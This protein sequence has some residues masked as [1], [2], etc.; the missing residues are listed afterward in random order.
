M[1][2][3]QGVTPEAAF[4]ALGD[5]LRTTILRVFADAEREG[6]QALTFTEIYERTPTDSTSRLSYHLD[7]LCEVFLRRD[8][9]EY[10]L[11]RAGDRVV[12]AILAGTY[13]ERPTFEPTTV[14]G[15]C[16]ACAATTLRAT[17][18]DEGLVV[19]CETCETTVV[20]Y[21][22]PPAGA[23]GQSSEE[24]LR[25]CDRRSHFEY[26]TALEGACPTCGGRVAVEIERDDDPATHY[27]VAECRSC[28]LRL[29][30]PL[31]VR[32][33][34]H[35]AV[36]AFY[37]EHGVDV[38]AVTFWEI[39]EFTRRWETTVHSDEPFQ[40]TV[41]IA[42]EDEELHLAVDEDLNVT[43]DS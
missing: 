28:H 9:G 14:D 42:F 19:A 23:R 20:T 13:S 26:A 29:Y 39:Y 32:L 24:I 21:D 5:E 41:E 34:Y 4:T 31:A 30:A 10:R 8:D 35:P 16:P 36:V 40:A 43:V 6:T 33:L 1:A 2:D 38:L 12:R 7:E 3:D 15:S 27:C 22:L 17:Y 25:T 11:T 37:W 18:R